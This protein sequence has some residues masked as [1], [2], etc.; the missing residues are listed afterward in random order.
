MKKRGRKR[1]KKR[2]FL[3][4]L[5]G[6]DLFLAAV[7]LICFLVMGALADLLPSQQAAERWQGESEMAFTQLSC[8][9]PAD[10]KLDIDQIYKFR[11]D[12][13]SKFHEAALDVD[14]DNQLYVDAWSTSGKVTATTAIGSG[15]ASVIAV[16]GE[17][18]NFHPIRLLS[19]SYLSERDLMQDKV[20]LDPEMAW[21]L[22][23]GVDLQ[24]MELRINGVPFIVGGVVER[25]DDFA[26]RE[27]YTAGMGLYMSYDAYSR[28]VADAGI[29]CY[30]LVAAEP[31]KGFAVSMVRAIFPIGQG[32]IRENSVRYS[33]SSLLTAA[34]Q[35]ARRSMQTSGTMI[36]YWENAARLV[37]TWSALLLFVGMV[38]CLLPAVTV[39]V[40]LIK[41]LGR[42]KEKLTEEVFP[43]IGDRVQEAIRVRQ[44]KAWEKRHRGRHEKGY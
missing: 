44:R 27:A 15:E 33:F 21:L 11:M 8:F 22:F 23:G 16:G 41:G 30:E 17:F 1:S 6:L 29:S 12:M 14:N 28:L 2:I 32:E 26:S 40:F 37:E 43:A 36:P 35:F 24:G 4:G 42:L 13:Q 3:I 25:E 5:I 31:V 20:L 38:L 10:G 18:F 9:L 39:V 19:G 34:V 7:A